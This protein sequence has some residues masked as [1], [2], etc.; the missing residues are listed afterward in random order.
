MKG[1][2]YFTLFRIGLLYLSGI[3]MGTA[4]GMMIAQGALHAGGAAMTASMALVSV[5]VVLGAYRRNGSVRAPS[6]PAADATKR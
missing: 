6:R 2:L 1:H 3:A 4:I 5:S